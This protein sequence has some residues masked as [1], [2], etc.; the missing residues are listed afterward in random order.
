[1][2]TTSEMT[3]KD[4]INYHHNRTPD[5][6]R[7]CPLQH[8]GIKHIPTRTK[9]VDVLFILDAPTIYSATQGKFIPDSDPASTSVVH[10]MN[11]ELAAY[12]QMLVER[13]EVVE[14]DVNHDYAYTVSC[15]IN[16]AVPSNLKTKAGKP[17][18]ALINRCHDILFKTIREMDPKIIIPVGE[19]AAKALYIMYRK[20]NSVVARTTHV[21]V[22]DKLYP[23]IPLLK[24]EM[25]ARNDNNYAVSKMVVKNAL[26]YIYEQRQFVK[27]EID[28]SKYLFPRTVEEVRDICRNII[29]PRTTG[30]NRSFLALD[31][32]TNTKYPY[33]SDARV[34]MLSFSW[35]PG[36]ACAIW[37]DSKYTPYDFNDVK[38]YIQEVLDTH[39]RKVF[40]NGG[41]DYKFLHYVC[42]FKIKN[43]CWDTMLTEH[44]LDENMKNFYNLEFLAGKYVP[45][46]ENYKKLALKKI[47]QKDDLHN[48]S[49]EED[50]N[51][52]KLVGVVVDNEGYRQSLQKYEEE[53]AAYQEDRDSYEIRMV[54]YRQEMEYWDLKYK[55]ANKVKLKDLDREEKARIQALRA[56]GRACKPVKPVR[57]FKKKPTKPDLDKYLGEETKNNF[58]DY[59]P[60]D[61]AV[62]CA[63]DSD[64]TR[65]LAGKQ[66]NKIN[67][68]SKTMKKII[69]EQH[70]PAMKALADMEYR[71][72]TTDQ[73]YLDQIEAEL[74]E[75]HERLHDEMVRISQNSNFKINSPKQVATILFSTFGMKM[76]PDMMSESGPTMDKEA[77]LYYAKVAAE[78]KGIPRHLIKDKDA[79]EKFL[80][81]YDEDKTGP[82]YFIGR[83]LAYRDV[84][85]AFTTTINNFRKYTAYDGKLRTSYHQNGTA[86]GRLSSS[87]PN[88]Q[89]I[90]KIGGGKNLKK[91][92]VPDQ[93]DHVLLQLDI[94]AAE[95]RC[96]M[97]YAKEPSLIEAIKNGDDFHCRTAS[98][99]WLGKFPEYKDAESLY[100]DLLA[101]H[102]AEVPTPEQKAMGEYRYKTKA[103][104]FGLVYGITRYGLSRDLGCSEDEAQETI[105]NYFRRYK[106]IK[107]YMDDT[108]VELHKYQEVQSLTGR[109]RRFPRYDLN[110]F[111]AYRQAINFKIQNI[112][113]DLVVRC[114]SKMHESVGQVLGGRLVLTVHDSV[115][116]SMP[117]RNL[118]LVKDYMDDIIVKYV[119]ETYPWLP[120]AFEYDLEWGFNY[121]ELKKLTE[122][123]YAA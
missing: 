8:C 96:L 123:D 17:N 50:F 49:N 21:R 89:N 72:A 92:I 112:A 55:D 71:G 36:E 16:D 3:F 73:S 53:L 109:K 102:N 40:H 121:G 24:G 34:L 25:I 60:D 30:E 86:T 64:I 104:N 22:F 29:I 5:A 52:Q 94:K 69:S 122:S 100:Q 20:Y 37:Y 70:I 79:L 111:R 76:N 59:D 119:A 117:R 42:G 47:S 75:E 85:K 11:S 114:L 61:L 101:A 4:M 65:V 45:S 110:P 82:L 26:D 81:K 10:L 84:N 91:F 120:V 48:E 103:V 2:E 15:H 87:A 12:K 107:K 27:Q 106:G 13:E 19:S 44:L 67:L 9:A 14:F 66:L 28:I 56:E 6:C 108:R 58:E 63:M 41:F 35:A 18:T 99:V 95:I 105:D 90:A 93:E 80:Y 78:E 33:H 23:A 83:L 7:R 51:P 1:M 98:D 97:A 116:I 43:I 74:K 38:P 115:L 31:V 39:S 62:Y 88:L 46:Y 68:D 57:K 32:E 77:L 54:S 118:K 113:S